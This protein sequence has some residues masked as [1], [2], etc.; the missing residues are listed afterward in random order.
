M[1]MPEPVL[2]LAGFV[3]AHAA[4]IVSGL[5]EDELLCPFAV[6]ERGGERK[7]SVFEAGTQTEAVRNGRDFVAGAVTDSEAWAFAREGIFRLQDRKVDVISVD[8]W[9]KGMDSPRT[10][11]QVFQPPAGG[12]RFRVVGAPLF[13]R[14]G[15]VQEGAA[16]E[17]AVSLINQG[18]QGHAK[19]APLWAGWQGAGPGREPCMN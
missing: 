15:V 9:S 10:L 4:W 2:Q 3:L 17:G 12:A 11:I 18:I 8:Y 13:V 16:A 7:L 5:G 19:A 6:V 14:D 1:D